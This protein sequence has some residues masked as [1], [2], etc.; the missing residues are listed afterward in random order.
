MCFPKW[1]REM[2]NSVNC[3]AYVIY[4]YTYI[5]TFSLNRRVKPH[6]F[7]D[8]KWDG[9]N[10]AYG[11]SLCYRLW[12]NSANSEAHENNGGKQKSLKNLLITHRNA[13]TLS[14]RRHMVSL[15][16]HISKRNWNLLEAGNTLFGG[17]EKQL[18][19]QNR[20]TYISQGC[21]L[22][23]AGIGGKSVWLKWKKPLVQIGGIG[24]P[25]STA[26]APDA[27]TAIGI[28]SLDHCRQSHRVKHSHSCSL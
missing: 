11:T 18:S 25:A 16:K 26:T 17:G 7:K 22:W 12:D 4:I 27:P 13:E 24:T 20:G 10:C 5:Y 9:R 1:S 19:T 23:H 21:G 6:F 2:W 28:Y 15:S 14:N 8:G 3:I